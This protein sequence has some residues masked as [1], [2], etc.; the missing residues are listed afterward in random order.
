MKK[1]LEEL[2]TSASYEDCKRWEE[3]IKTIDDYDP[4]KSEEIL[5]NWVK[6]GER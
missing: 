4:N 5:D 6:Y 1:A 2:R 3:L